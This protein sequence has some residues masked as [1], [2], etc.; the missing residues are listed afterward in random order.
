MLFQ[1]H[2]YNQCV[3]LYEISCYVIRL[4]AMCEEFKYHRHNKRYYLVNISAPL[5]HLTASRYRVECSKTIVNVTAFNYVHLQFIYNSI[6][7]VV[8]YIDIV[9]CYSSNIF[10]Y[11]KHLNNKAD[12][13]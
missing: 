9:W 6:K 3:K 1:N 12:V 5:I 11:M 13:T 4:F 7:Q 2:L 8:L 10:R